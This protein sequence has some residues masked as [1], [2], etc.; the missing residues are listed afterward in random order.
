MAQPIA[1]CA[2]AYGPAD[3]TGLDVNLELMVLS[4]LRHSQRS[5]VSLSTMT[6]RVDFPA[7]T[8]ELPG[9]ASSSPVRSAGP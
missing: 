5:V 6:L 7:R 2:R 4:M 9:F 1:G 8:L 3:R